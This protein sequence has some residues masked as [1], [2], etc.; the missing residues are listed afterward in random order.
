MLDVKSLFQK[1]RKLEAKATPGFWSTKLEHDDTV[2]ELVGPYT[3]AEGCSGPSTEF[4]NHDD[5]RLICEMRNALPKLL[6]VIDLYE[7]AMEQVEDC[8]PNNGEIEAI[9][10]ETLNRV[11]E[12][13]GE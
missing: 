7:M 4:N 5:A 13:A 12:L 2:M 1:L 10:A 9:C 11:E 6:A 3:T 8:C